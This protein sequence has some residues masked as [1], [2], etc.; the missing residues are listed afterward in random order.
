M[1]IEEITLIWVLVLFIFSRQY[2]SRENRIPHSR[3]VGNYRA[4]CRSASAY[5]ERFHRSTAAGSH[6]SDGSSNVFHFDYDAPLLVEARTG[7]A[8]LHHRHH[9]H[10][11]DGRSHHCC[12]RSPPSFTSQKSAQN[13]QSLSPSVRR[14]P[15]NRLK[16]KVA[17]R[18]RAAGVDLLAGAQQQL[19]SATYT[20]DELDDGTRTI[21]RSQDRPSSLG[22]EYGQDQNRN[23]DNRLG[24]SAEWG[25]ANFS[26]IAVE[27]NVCFYLKK[28]Y[29]SQQITYFDGFKN[30]SK[31]RVFFFIF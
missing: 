1:I 28:I 11:N 3:S 31:I 25:G 6:T 7:N 16:E 19:P 10:N 4:Q 13:R 23:N 15:V 24:V 12:R 22:T 14:S 30:Q 9:H 20:S 2:I 17:D 21:C 18:K 8:E 27:G 29:L 26:S 5:G